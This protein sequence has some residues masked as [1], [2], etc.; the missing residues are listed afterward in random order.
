M[1]TLQIISL[2]VAATL[3]ACRPGG[4]N[5][6]EYSVKFSEETLEAEPFDTVEILSGFVVELKKSDKYSVEVKYPAHFDNFLIQE[7][8]GNKLKL[9]FETTTE[10]NDSV[11]GFDSGEVYQFLIQNKPTAV[12]STPSPKYIRLMGG[13]ELNF[14]EGFTADDCTVEM[15]R[16]SVISGG[17]LN[18]RHLAVT[19]DDASDCKMN[20]SADSAEVSLRGS[21]SFRPAIYARSLTVDMAE[22]CSAAMTKL[23]DKRGDYFRLDISGSSMLDSGEI[24]FGKIEVKASG[25]S[26]AV[27]HPAR[28]LFVDASDESAVRY[29][30]TKMLVK[31]IREN[32]NASV[33]IE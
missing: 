16:A 17:S 32:D 31:E 10:L 22:S 27:V 8:S 6:A 3:F 20:I 11:N 9:G 18:A 25:A 30:F 13:S 23:I 1:K 12:I 4:S 26:E 2:I 29:I 21:A 33:R 14:G 19:M 15:R 24:P 28:M 7:I 5:E